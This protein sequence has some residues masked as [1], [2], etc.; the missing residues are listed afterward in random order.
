[1]Q[2]FRNGTNHVYFIKSI[3]KLTILIDLD[4]KCLVD[5][6]NATKIYLNVEKTVLN[7]RTVF[8]H[9]IDIK[10]DK[11]R[12]YFGSSVKYLRVKIYKNL[13]WHHYLNLNP[14]S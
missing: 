13:N 5:L 9:E 2:H 12:L 1:M 10:L 8:E 4:M 3:K 14:E 11:R 7:N 6:L